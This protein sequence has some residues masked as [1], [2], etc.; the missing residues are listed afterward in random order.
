MLFRE[1]CL[2]GRLS[3][4][5]RASHLPGEAEGTPIGVKSEWQFQLMPPSYEVRT[6]LLSSE[7]GT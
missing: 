6:A 1:Q 5:R 7:D 4:G 2:I 3:A